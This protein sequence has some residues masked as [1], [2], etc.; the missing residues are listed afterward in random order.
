MHLSKGSLYGAEIDAKPPTKASQ[1]HADL[2]GIRELDHS[3]GVLSEGRQPEMAAK[4]QHSSAFCKTIVL[5]AIAMISTLLLPAAASDYLLYYL[6]FDFLLKTRTEMASGRALQGTLQRRCP[7][8]NV[9][10][11]STRT[12][13]A[14][15]W[16]G[17]RRT[18]AGRAGTKVTKEASSRTTSAAVP[19]S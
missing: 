9:R 15:P 19:T 6:L 13:R 5:F 11:A 1:I 7:Q 14:L 2:T 10:W 18:A 3:G 17:R 16:K 8:H 4:L 12:R